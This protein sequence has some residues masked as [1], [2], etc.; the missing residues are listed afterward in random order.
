MKQNLF[1]LLLGLF[2]MS[3]LYAQNGNVQLYESNPKDKE[4]TH[5]NDVP[6]VNY[7]EDGVTLSSDSLISNV[8]IIIKD[9]NGHVM[10]NEQTTLSPVEKVLFVPDEDESHKYTIELVYDKKTLYG[11][12]E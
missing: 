7:D 11:Y 9:E 5:R 10:C 8:A 1:L 4:G 6:V 2:T 3:G 12:F